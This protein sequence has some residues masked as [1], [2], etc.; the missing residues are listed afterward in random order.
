LSDEYRTEVDR[1]WAEEI[2]RRA[3]EIDEGQ[4]TLVPWD[5]VR[6]RLLKR[7]VG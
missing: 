5:Q 1:A 3:K 4:V 7:T 2:E 6:D